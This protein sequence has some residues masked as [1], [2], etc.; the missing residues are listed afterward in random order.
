MLEEVLVPVEP[1]SKFIHGLRARLVHYKGDRIASIWFGMAI[2]G[3]AL[4]IV[5][6]LSTFALRLAIA[7]LAGIELLSRRKREK[8]R[9]RLRTTEG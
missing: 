5:V 9:V 6:A 2:I 8:G 1:S 4:L 3:T 7:I